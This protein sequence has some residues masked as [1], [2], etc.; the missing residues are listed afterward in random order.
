MLLRL[1]R[2]VS[3]HAAGGAVA[4]LCLVV[5][6]S[7]VENPKFWIQDAS[8]QGFGHSSSTPIGLDEESGVC[9]FKSVRTM[10]KLTAFSRQNSSQHSPANDSTAFSG[11]S[12]KNE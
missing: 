7:K 1:D 3:S 5:T 2:T 10:L 6:S 9:Y 4:R 12:E 11:T 8:L